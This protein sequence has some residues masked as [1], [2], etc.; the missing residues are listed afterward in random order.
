MSKAVLVIDMPE[1]CEHCRSRYIFGE[2]GILHRYIDEGVDKPDWCPLVPMP[3][4]LDASQVVV[5]GGRSNGKTKQMLASA[6]INGWN[7]CIDAI[8]G[9]K[10]NE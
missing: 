4:R 9:G 1:S 2:C 8:S 3:G 10:A 7:A 5:I 6:H